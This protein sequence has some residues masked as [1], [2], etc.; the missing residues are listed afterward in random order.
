MKTE[1]IVEMWNGDS[2]IDPTDLSGAALSS[3]RLHAK[4]YRIYM[5]EKDELMQL[6]GALKLLRLEKFEFYTQGPTEEVVANWKVKTLPDSG[7]IYKAD[8]QKYIDADLDV[9]NLE[10]RYNRQLE[11]VKFV[12][13]V[14]SSLR[15]RGY[16]IR[17]AID[18]MKFQMGA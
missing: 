12:E 10:L 7:T 3:P 5:Q 16:A 11:K 13:A 4:Y 15:D 6:A 8:V 17:N 18:F 9:M 14:I 2:R 1:E